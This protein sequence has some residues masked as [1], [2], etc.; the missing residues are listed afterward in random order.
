MFAFSLWRV[1]GY[2]LLAIVATI[3]VAGAFGALMDHLLG[4][5]PKGLVIGVVLSFPLS[6]IIAIR[7][8]KAKMAHFS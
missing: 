7:F 1:R 5:S 2:L 4:S 8:A 6:N 3:V